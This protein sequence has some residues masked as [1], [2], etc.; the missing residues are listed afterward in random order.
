MTPLLPNVA[1]E[2][3]NVA[4]AI[5]IDGI[6]ICHL[7]DIAS[8]LATKQVDELGPVDVLLVPTGGGCTLNLDQVLQNM[9]DLDPKIVIPMH[10]RTPGLDIP[11]QGV[12]AFLSRMGLSD[13]QPQPRLVVTASNLSP[14]VHGYHILVFV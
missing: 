5:E 2:Y 8:P 11:L 7:G 14:E 4:Y 9:Q 6:N 13:V 12:D 10:Y 1:R 3:R